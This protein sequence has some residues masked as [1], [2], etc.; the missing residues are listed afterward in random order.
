MQKAIMQ[1]S[2]HF[3]VESRIN[4]NTMANQQINVNKDCHCYT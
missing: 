1:K 4:E 2:N 3:S